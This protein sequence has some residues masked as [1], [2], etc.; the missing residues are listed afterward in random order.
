MDRD[1][2]KICCIFSLVVAKN[3][4]KFYFSIYEYDQIFVILMKLE[5]AHVL[6]IWTETISTLDV[7][8]QY[9]KCKYYQYQW[10]RKVL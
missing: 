8:K 5:R 2:A 3:S 1:S 7:G 4:D 10:L 6:N 9:H